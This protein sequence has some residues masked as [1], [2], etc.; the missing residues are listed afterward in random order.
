ME[1]GGHQLP[2]E[3]RQE[4]G[5]MIAGAAT[6][7]VTDASSAETASTLL[8]AVKG[9][10][11]QVKK[12]FGPLKKAAKAA[13]QAIV[14]QEKEFL[15]PINK[16]GSAI[17]TKLAVYLEA[18]RR[19]AFEESE[20]ERLRLKAIETAR[21][22]AEAEQ[23]EAAGQSLAAEAARV[24]PVVVEEVAP[25]PVVAPAGVHTRETWHAE[26]VDLNA[27]IQHAAA[28]TRASDFL[29]ANMPTLNLAARRR[30][31]EDIG[32]PGVRGVRIVTTV[33]G[34]A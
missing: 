25:A 11:S 6:L 24:T 32:I 31:Q 18:E 23:L 14:N 7:A 5:H 26:V 30:K 29:L 13:H 10:A 22:K 12:C 20:R 27:L 33:A 19:K 1:G 9:L 3:L 16:A 21:L 15:A 8:T 28:D 17:G 2:V 4:A 34:G